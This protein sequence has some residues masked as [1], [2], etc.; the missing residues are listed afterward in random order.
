[1]GTL[2]G[3]VFDFE[4]D[5]EKAAI[6]LRKH[7]ISFEEASSIFDDDLMITEADWM[8]SDEED[9][10]VSIGLSSQ[11]T[12]LVVSYT[13]KVRTVRLI[14]AREPTSREKQSYEN[15]NS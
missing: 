2:S 6:N 3:A 5:D 4:W 1:M 10:Y 15:D 12:L 13:E 11:N 8:H 14:S 7:R 9:R